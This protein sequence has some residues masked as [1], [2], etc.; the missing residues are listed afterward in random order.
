MNNSEKGAKLYFIH[1][2]FINKR[3]QSGDGNISITINEFIKSL[4]HIREIED[5]LI[6]KYEYRSIVINNFIL[7]DEAVEAG[8]NEIFTSSEDL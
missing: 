8:S 1:F 5:M 4:E 7:L 6:K 2:T 3:H